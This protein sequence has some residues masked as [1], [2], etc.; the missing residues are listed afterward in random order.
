MIKINPLAVFRQEMD[1]NAIL[2]NPESG[3]IFAL[4]PTGRVIWQALA[5]GLDRDA[6]LDK[7]A[8]KCRTPLPPEAAQD[9]DEFLAALKRK[10]FLADE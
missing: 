7:L 5:E 9:L 3:E 8:E 2:F 10:G 1:D 4:N 6:V